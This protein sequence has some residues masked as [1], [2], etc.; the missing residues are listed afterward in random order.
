M[1]D[2]QN[3]KPA[4]RT[5]PRTWQ[6]QSLDSV[7]LLAIQI[8]SGIVRLYPE[9]GAAIVRADRESTTPFWEEIDT[10]IRKELPGVDMVELARLQEIARR[11]GE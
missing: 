3:P 11:Q 10:L 1:T 9:I 4:A 2:S 6:M 7:E 8:F 5:Q